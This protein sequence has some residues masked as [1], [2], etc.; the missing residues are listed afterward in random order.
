[1][2]GYDKMKADGSTLVDGAL[3]ASRFEFRS[4][5]RIVGFVNTSYEISATTHV[6]GLGYSFV[7][8]HEHT[9]GIDAHL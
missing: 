7:D 1:M 2:H 3:L 8:I 6:H 5:L 9:I 4:R